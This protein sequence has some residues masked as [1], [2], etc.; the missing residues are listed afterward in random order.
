MT[1]SLTLLQ[2]LIGLLSGITALLLGICAYGFSVHPAL[3]FSTGVV[4]GL[5]LSNVQFQVVN[6]AVATIVVCFAE[7]PSALVEN[8]P[9]EVSSRLIRAW[10]QA[11]PDECGF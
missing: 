6:S 3:M 1:R 7:A 10:R 2:I 9:P 4:L 5:I 11:Y 8:H